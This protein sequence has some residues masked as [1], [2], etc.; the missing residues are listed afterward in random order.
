MP[1]ATPS[2]ATMSGPTQGTIDDDRTQPRPLQR[3]SI[4]LAATPFRRLVGYLRASARLAVPGRGWR[5]LATGYCHSCGHTSIFVIAM[6]EAKWIKQTVDSWDGGVV[7]KRGME[8][9]EA[10]ICFR[11]E[12]SLRMRL[13]AKAALAALHY[14][15]LHDL[16]R[17]LTHDPATRIY[18][19]AFWNVFRSTELLARGNYV[20]SEYRKTCDLGSVVNGIRNE[21]LEA[22]TFDDDSF[23]VVITSDVLEHV[24]HLERA[25]AEIR[26]VLKLGGWHIFTVP[27]DP[28]LEHT[29]E[30]AQYVDGR[31]VHLR[32]PVM[33]GDVV[34]EDGILAFR[35]FGNDTVEVMNRAGFDCHEQRYNDEHGFVTSVFVARKIPIHST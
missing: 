2:Q 7:F 32:P 19:A 15:S 13:Q 12:A 6:N 16:L 24:G 18:E 27:S 28:E 22:L 21:D 17:R 3:Q 31:I 9:R 30:R 26:R 23:D 35:D 34:R 14:G 8:R 4:A 5:Y 29:V 1:P 33:H 25:L 10:D 20:T 11:C